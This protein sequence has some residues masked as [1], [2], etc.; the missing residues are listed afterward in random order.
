VSGRLWRDF[1]RATSSRTDCAGTAAFT[2]S[3]LGATPTSDTGASAFNGSKGSFGVRCGAMVCVP[4]E[5]S[6]SV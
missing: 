3:A 2:T 1:A 5:P 6:M 4:V